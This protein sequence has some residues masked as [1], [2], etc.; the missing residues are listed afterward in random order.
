MFNL[1]ADRE[2]L[3]VNQK[4]VKRMESL[5]KYGTALTVAG[6]DK[7]VKHIRFHARQVESGVA[8]A[9]YAWLMPLTE[10]PPQKIAATAVRVVL[11]QITQTTKLHAL[12]IE[13]GQM[14]WMETMLNKATRWE[15][16]L[17][18]QVRHRNDGKRKDVLRKIAR[19]FVIGRHVIDRRVHAFLIALNEIVVRAFVARLSPAHQITIRQI[20]SGDLCWNRVVGRQVHG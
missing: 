19:V 18:K 4:I 9:K 20:H 12:A 8:G 10:L 15:R 2:E 1:G 13:V 3:M 6:V 17:H 7:L 5:S 14:L 11:D 16:K